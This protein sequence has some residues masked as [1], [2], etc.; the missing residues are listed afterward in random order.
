MGRKIILDL[1]SFEFIESCSLEMLYSGLAYEATY[2][3]K[4]FE[5][6]MTKIWVDPIYTLTSLCY[7]LDRK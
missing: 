2:Y 7:C 3:D 4:S 6:I 5:G 1:L